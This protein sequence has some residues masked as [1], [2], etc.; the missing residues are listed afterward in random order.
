MHKCDFQ[1]GLAV[2]DIQAVKDN[3]VIKRLEMQVKLNLDIEKRLPM[4]LRRRLTKRGVVLK[5]NKKKN[6]LLNF[7]LDDYML[8]II[9]QAVADGKSHVC[10]LYV[11]RYPNRI[12][13]YI[14][15]RVIP[16]ARATVCTPPRPTETCSRTA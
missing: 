12:N 9:V 16:S 1:V 5:P 10:G 8:R 15:P 6:F 4:W 2:D 7:F 13:N 3:A 14:Y 11:L